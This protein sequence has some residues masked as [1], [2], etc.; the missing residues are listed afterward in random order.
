[1]IDLEELKSII[2]SADDREKLPTDL[3]LLE[4]AS[5]QYDKLVEEGLIEPRG[6]TLL[7]VEA[8]IAEPFMG[9]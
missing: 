9:Y 3:T 7:T 5:E 1:M 6:Y 4:E 8:S 2:K